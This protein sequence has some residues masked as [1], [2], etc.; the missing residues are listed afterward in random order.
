MTQEGTPGQT[1]EFRGYPPPSSNTVYCPN[2]FF[3]VV[4]PHSSRGVVR[5]VGYLL[6]QTLGWSDA[7]GKPQEE[8]IL[9]S[10]TDLVNRAGISRG[11]IGEAIQEALAARFIECVREGRP[12]SNGKSSVSALYQLRWDERGEYVKDPAA[13]QGFFSGQGNCTYIPNLFF[14]YTLPNEPLTVVKVVGAIIRNTIGFQT[15]RGF[16]RQRVAMSQ[17][18]IREYMNLSKFGVDSGLAEAGHKRHIEVVEKGLFDKNAGMA[19]KA[20]TYAVHWSDDFNALGEVEN[21]SGSKIRAE[22]AVQNS[23][24]EPGERFKNQGGT[25]GSEFR[26]APVQKSGREQSKNQGGI[27]EITPSNN[28][29]KQQQGAATAAWLA[30]AEEGQRHVFGR[31]VELG[32]D[33]KTAIRLVVEN[34]PEAV[35][36]QVHAL[37]KRTPTQNPAGML[38]KSIEENWPVPGDAPDTAGTTFVREFFRNLSG[39]GAGEAVAPVR[40]SDVRS[41]EDFLAAAL[42][43]VG[44]NAKDLAKRFVDYAKRREP[45]DSRR[46]GS[47]PSLLAIHGGAFVAEINQRLAGERKRVAERQAQEQRKNLEPAFFVYLVRRLEELRSEAPALFQEYAQEEDRLIIFYGKPS[48]IMSEGLRKRMLEDI[49]KPEERAR[50]IEKFFTEQKKSPLVQSFRDWAAGRENVLAFE[51]AN[52]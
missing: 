36:R 20:T 8:R 52:P 42:P 39:N 48:P 44:G 43:L 26:A 15:S 6:R 33:A 2:Q 31:L 10:Y 19:S 49:A 16:R 25:S 7:D 38:R 24:R 47:L 28:T 11:A 50:R 12:C 45:P 34:G 1:G 51:K 40:V 35:N 37:A 32:L 41:C 9:A 46:M 21:L 27:E 17:E 3:D 29:P 13:F 23:G 14:D 5:L 4:L 30:V 22:K 18:E